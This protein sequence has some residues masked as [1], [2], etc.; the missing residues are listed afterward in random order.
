VDGVDFESS[1]EYY[2]TKTDFRING[3]WSQAIYFEARPLE[4]ASYERI[5]LSIF[6]LDGTGELTRDNMLGQKVVYVLLPGSDGNIPKVTFNE[7][8]P[9]TIYSAGT[10]HLYV[11]CGNSNILETSLAAGICEFYAYSAD[12]KS[13]VKIPSRSI[14]FSEGIAD[15]VIEN[16]KDKDGKEVVMPTGGW[17]LQLEWSN[18]ALTQGVVTEAYQKQT[19]QVLN[20]TVSDDPKFRNDTY[21]I[22]AAV[23]YGVRASSEDPLRYELR[24]FKDEADLEKF[25]KK[26][27][28]YAAETYKE[29]LLVFRGQFVGD[30]QYAYRDEYGNIQWYYYYTAVSNKTVDETTRETKVDNMITINNCLDF[31]GGTMTIY[32]EDYKKAGSTVGNF[33]GAKNSAICVEFDG[34][35]YTSVERSSVWTGKAALTKLTQ[36]DDYSLITYDKNGNRTNSNS[37]ASQINLI[38]PNVFGYA[39]KLAGGVF[40][41]AY[42]QFGVMK[43]GANEIGRVLSFSASFSLSFLRTP[44]D[45]EIDQGTASYFGRM[46]ELW[47]N[48]RGASI[49]Q[50]AYNGGRYEKLTKLDMNDKDTSGDDKKGVQGAVMVQDVLF[51]CGVGFVGLNFNVSIGFK[52][53]IDGLPEVTGK[54]KVNTINDWSFGFDGKMELA[55]FKME[56]SLSFKSKDNIP[57]PDNIYFFIGGFKPGINV[58]GCGVLWL[59]GGGGGIS[60]LYDTIFM[61]SGLPPLK[62][63]LTVSFNIV[64]LL[65]ARASLELSL[66]GLSLSA[67]DIKFADTITVV[68]KMTLGLQWLPDL[69]LSASIYVDMFEKTICGNG[70]IVLLGKEY[71]DWF[72]EMFARVRLQI[73]SSVPAV[74]GM[75]LLGVDVGIS[76]SKIWGAV[77]ALSFSIGITYYWGEDDFHIGSGGDFAK[78]TY[79]SML[80]L[81]GYDGEPTSFPILHDEE[82]GRTL[83]AQVGTNFGAPQEAQVLSEGD[84]VLMDARGVWSTLD[85]TVHKFNLGAAGEDDGMVQV[86]YK[87]TSLANAKAIANG[88]AIGSNQDGSG[89]PFELRFVQSVDRQQYASETDEAYEAHIASIVAANQNANANVTWNEETGIATLCFSVT[90]DAQFDRNW[91]LVTGNPNGEPVDVLLYN[92]H[93]IPKM[94]SVRFD[95]MDS[96][97]G[98]NLATIKWTGVDLDK[99]EKI[100]LALCK[101]TDPTEAGYGAFEVNGDYGSCPDDEEAQFPLSND[102]PSGDY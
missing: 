27:A 24:T 74:G 76:E 17:Y 95:S 25:T 75:T 73:P 89:T 48:W 47:K 88:F 52:N 68:K 100:S 90:D 13:S 65:S 49:Y 37:S 78:P 26:E 45:S 22:I 66:S 40:K 62:L 94:T 43:D 29:I 92:V 67:T 63:I 3:T 34:D 39:Q 14:T 11:A 54:L 77:E 97:G 20:F 15:I 46:S 38:W 98:M 55:T 80:T 6:K 7:M 93:G 58:D 72:F 33:Q 96:S 50:Y 82:K 56:A 42:G 86:N 32:Y 81:Q 70:Y 91:Y 19:A 5:T 9:S 21:G 35:L 8:S 102:L 71:T 12:G 31:E 23:K 10:R 53:F 83:Y 51:G 61:T 16:E 44:A 60:N 84:L 79:P 59:T 69:K 28:P 30:K 2:I 85:K 18:D 101:T 4:S 87:A 1:R 36:G 41:L 57:V 99:M 64:Q